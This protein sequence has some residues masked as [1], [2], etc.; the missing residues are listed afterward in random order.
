MKEETVKSNKEL[1]CSLARENIHREGLEDLLKFID[2][3]T[4]FWTAPAST[5]FH[6]NFDGGLCKH[7]MNVFEVASKI[8]D[9]VEAQI[10]SGNSPYKEED[11]SR[12]SLA[13]A[14]LFHDLC[15]I[16]TYKKVE[17][18]RKDDNNQWETYVTFASDTAFPLGHGEKSALIAA[19]FMK[20]TK[21]EYLAIRWHS[22]NY[23][24]SDMTRGDYNKAMS[25]CPL[26]PIIISADLIAT[27]DLEKIKE[28]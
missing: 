25:S 22:G 16:N 17:K 9:E 26:M 14:C 4:D 19:Q 5:K 28:Y 20:L 2:E 27:F 3:H 24:V 13:I 8:Y 23:D 6:S 18:W 12:E 7:S 15:K 11:L 10:I 1:F 21:D